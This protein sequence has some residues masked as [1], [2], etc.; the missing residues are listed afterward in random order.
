M[1]RGYTFI[2]ERT[3]LDAIGVRFVGNI[4]YD[5]LKVDFIMAQKKIAVTHLGKKST[6]SVA[7]SRDRIDVFL[8]MLVRERFF[9]ESGPRS[10]GKVADDK[11]TDNRQTWVFG[12][13]IQLMAGDWP[14]KVFVEQNAEDVTVTYFMFMPWGWIITLAVMIFFFLPFIPIDGAPL[15]FFLGLGVIA[16]AIY[17][18]RFDC[19]PN[20]SWQGPPRQR[21]NN[22]MIELVTDAFR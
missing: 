17:K 22:R 9:M 16:L 19:S 20:A 5:P 13:K 8:E 3:H 6:V 11:M 12:R 4:Q 7:A 21:W 2:H 14:M 18:Q 10:D 1:L 15:V